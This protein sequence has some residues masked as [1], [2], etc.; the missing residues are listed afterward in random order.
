VKR[1]DLYRVMG[2]AGAIAVLTWLSAPVKTL[3]A[4]GAALSEDTPTLADE[5]SQSPTDEPIQ[6]TGVQLT[7]TPTGLS[8]TLGTS[9]ELTLPVSTSTIGNALII[10]IPNAALALPE[11]DEFQTANPAEGMALVTIS[12]LPDNVVRVALTGTAAPPEADVQIEATGLVLSIEVGEAVA[13][14]PSTDLPEEEALQIVVTAQRREEDIQ[15]VPI[16]ITVLTADQIEDADIV[17]LEGIAENA[18]NFSVFSASGSRSF[19]NYSI[20]GLSNFNFAS[21][22]AVGFYVDDVPYDFGGFITQDFI[23][24]ERVEVLRGPQNTLYGRSSQAGVV[25]IITRRPTD[26]FEF[27]GTVG[28]GAYNDLDLRASTSGPIVEDQLFFRLAGSYG[29]RDGYFENTLLGNRL[30]DQSGGNVRGQLL[31]TPSDNWEILLNASVDVYRDGG[32]PL[33]LVN[34]NPFQVERDVPGFNNLDTNAQSLRIAYNDPNFR[35]TSI[36]S[37]RFSRRDEETDLDFS[38]LRTGRLTNIF[39]STVITQELRFQSPEDAQQWQWIVGGYYESRS[40]NT[41]NDGFRFDQDAPLVFGDFGL[42]GSSLLRSADIDESL[43]AGFGQISYQPIEA[44]TLTA[45]LRYE[46]INSRLNRFEQVLTLPDGSASPILEFNNVEQRGDILLPR[47][48]IDYRFNPNLMVYGSI[49]RG[50]RPGGVNYAPDNEASL[51]FEAER[52]WNYEVGV[53]SSWLDNQLGFNLAVFHNPVS[54]YQVINFDPLTGIPLAISNA[55]A[56]L[57]GFEAELRATPI[58]GL[59]LIA[60]LGFVN[61]RFTNYQDA[62]SGAVFDGNRLPFAPDW[63]Y[64]LALQYRHPVGV[65]ARAEL[66]GLGQTFF[67]EANILEQPSYAIVNARLGYEFD[68]YGI[69]AFGN[70]IFNRQYLTAAFGLV[71]SELGQYGSPA[72]YGIQFRAQF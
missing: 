44:L 46:S 57:T 34:P 38:A 51:T 8:L 43:W 48:A 15:N 41:A 4:E 65:F 25:N 70:N 23:D 59:D 5:L 52:S 60:G 50:Y 40:F 39:D 32:I 55:D 58:R 47:L 13:T 12:A 42:P 6:I 1:L 33:V 21:R 63:T 24:L 31:W 16:S 29:R 62:A 54:N 64:N 26:E 3:G 69:Y 56:E 28:Y 14:D 22:D 7:T 49:A 37:R 11:G 27:S 53:K 68:N 19:N 35:A 66:V 67:D 72:T 61:T 9:S 10:D 71:G 36:T 18:P 2:I 30:D 20:R 17:T 45:G